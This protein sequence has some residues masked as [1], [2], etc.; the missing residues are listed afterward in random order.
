[1]PSVVTYN[2]LVFSLGGGKTNTFTMELV[3]INGDDKPDLIFGTSNDIAF[4]S[5]VYLNRNNR[6]DIVDALIPI[7]VQGFWAIDIVVKDSIIYFYGLKN[8]YDT[9]NIY[10]YNFQTKT[11]SIIYDSNGKRWPNAN[12]DIDWV[13]MIP[14][15]G[16]LV[17]LSDAYTGVSVPM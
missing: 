6:F 2:P 9:I 4:P 5:R 13:W 15:N 10:K 3:D 14:Y 16:N 1:M 8:Y 12:I 17:P 7:G 11:G